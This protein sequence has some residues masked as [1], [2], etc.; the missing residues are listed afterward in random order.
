MN[1]AFMSH[2]VERWPGLL[3]QLLKL[4]LCLNQK[5]NVSVGVF[6]ERK[7]I[8]ISLARLG[9]VALHRGG[10]CER[11]VRER[12]QRRERDSDHDGPGSCVLPP[13]HVL[14]GPI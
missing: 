6:P 8:L 4:P 2:K 3:L 11:Q 12:P 9:G 13:R 5:R 1:R 10:S 7:E 14:P